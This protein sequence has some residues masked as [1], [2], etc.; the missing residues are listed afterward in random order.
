MAQQPPAPAPPVADPNKGLKGKIFALKHL[1]QNANATEEQLAAVDTFDSVEDVDAA[2]V[3]F[4]PN[5]D[6]TLPFNNERPIDA[7]SLPFPKK[8]V[9]GKAGTPPGELPATKVDN[10]GIFSESLNPLAVQNFERMNVEPG[11][12]VLYRKNERTGDWEVF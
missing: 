5:K 2:A 11:A 6:G 1:M 7:K 3:F 12:A 4:R 9:N 8:V 10:K